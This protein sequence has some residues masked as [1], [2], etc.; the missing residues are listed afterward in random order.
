MSKKTLNSQAWID[1]LFEAHV[2]GSPSPVCASRVPGVDQAMAYSVQAGFIERCATASPVSGFKG[3]LTGKAAQESMGID[4]PVSGVLL[5]EMDLPISSV[6]ALENF[7]R[8]VVETEVGFCIGKQ[9]SQPITA[10]E[11]P[12]YVA[13]FV[14][15]I[16]IA[17]ID[18]DDP[19]AMTIYDFIASGAA[20]AGYIAGEKS[21]FHAVN[22][23]E[24]TLSRDG[25]LLHEGRGT[26]ALGDQ[27]AAATW[28]INQVVAQGYVIEPGHVL[29]TGSLGRVQMHTKPGLYFADYG[30]FGQIEFE[31]R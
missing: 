23:V 1:L 2:R 19:G 15:M 21:D 28:L 22:E 27:F 17:D 16:E 12:D 9:V 13:Y 24:V 18:F 11:L 4:V 14:P 7:S 6:I 31:I 5:A 29:M 10:E 26:D 3:A 20:A 8:A 25:E 30:D